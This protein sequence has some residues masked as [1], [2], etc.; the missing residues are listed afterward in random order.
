MTW[1]GEYTCIRMSRFRHHIVWVSRFSSPVSPTGFQSSL[2]RLPLDFNAN[3]AVVAD[4]LSL[5]RSVLSRARQIFPFVL[6]VDTLAVVA[7]F[8]A[9]S[10]RRSC[11]FVHVTCDIDDDL[12]FNI[13]LQQVM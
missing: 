6:V 2:V 11:C 3:D 12:S 10:V 8:F 9:F 13:T 7:S 4:R 5:F 1:Y